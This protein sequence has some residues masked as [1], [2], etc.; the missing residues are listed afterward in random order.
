[1]PIFRYVSIV[2]HYDTF[3]HRFWN[4]LVHFVDKVHY[5]RLDHQSV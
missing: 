2:I 5:D 3:T 4:I 1:M